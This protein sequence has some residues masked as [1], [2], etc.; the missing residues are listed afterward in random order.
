MPNT[1]INNR[2][3]EPIIIPTA[4]FLF[5][6]DDN[7]VITMQTIQRYNHGIYLSFILNNY[8]AMFITMHT[9]TYARTHAHTHTHTHTQYTKLPSVIA[10]VDGEP[11]DECPECKFC[12]IKSI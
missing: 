3:M 10:Q 6:T 8:I 12:I 1:Q 9:N 2:K 7:S 4:V 5:E 11:A